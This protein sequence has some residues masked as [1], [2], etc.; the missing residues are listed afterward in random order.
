MAARYGRGVAI[1]GQLSLTSKGDESTRAFLADLQN[2]LRILFQDGYK[3]T[4]AGMKMY[5]PV[6]QTEERHSRGRKIE[7]MTI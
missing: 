2:L 1:R 5:A 7:K 4:S 3:A 6:Q